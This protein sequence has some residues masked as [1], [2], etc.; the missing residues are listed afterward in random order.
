MALLCLVF[1]AF[2]QANP[3]LSE[4]TFLRVSTEQGLSQ[5]TVNTLL[6]DQNGFLWIGTFDGL[7]RYDGYRVESIAGN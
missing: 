4:P 1:S 7:N 3:L 6:I 2:A 5:D